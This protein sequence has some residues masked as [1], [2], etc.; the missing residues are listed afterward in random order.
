MEPEVRIADLVPEDGDAVVQAAE[1][2]V[3]GFREYWPEAWPDLDSAL[4]EVRESFAP[5]RISLAARDPEGRVVGWIGGIRQ[6]DG[7]VWEL[8][9]LVVHAAHRRR[10]IARAL[11]AA[12]ERRTADA[13]GITLWLGSDDMSGQTSLGGVDLYPDVLGHLARIR[14][15]RDHPYEVYQRLGFVITGV[16]PDASGPGRPDLFLA[17]RIGGDRAG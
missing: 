1:L 13:G 12:L 15:L 7:L 16:M 5:D 14:N 17:K 2:L 4:A 8:H 6:Y 9:P 11:V 3:E 10:G